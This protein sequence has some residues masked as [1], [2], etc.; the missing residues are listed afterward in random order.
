MSIKKDKEIK[1]SRLQSA[2][3]IITLGPGCG[4]GLVYF[5]D[6]VFYPDK[7]VI[8]EVGPFPLPLY[9]GSAESEVI[10]ALAES[11]NHGS[12]AIQKLYRGI[13]G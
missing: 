9:G 11:V 7:T 5:F 6:Q 10:L 12:R 13:G 8:E 3:K 1:R 4:G 2:I